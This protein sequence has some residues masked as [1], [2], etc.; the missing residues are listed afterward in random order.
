MSNGNELHALEN[1]DRGKALTVDEAGERFE[2]PISGWSVKR[3]HI[4]SGKAIEGKEDLPQL[5]AHKH[6]RQW[7]IFEKDL[8]EYLESKSN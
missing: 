3:Y 2:P 8:N 6:G 5:K 1:K 7:V 4:R